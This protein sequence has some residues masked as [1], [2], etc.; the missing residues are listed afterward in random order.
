[1]NRLSLKVLIYNDPRHG[2]SNNAV[3]ATSKGSDQPAHTRR[4]IRAFASRLNNPW[5]ICYWPYTI[6]KRWLLR[7]VWVYTCQKTTL[8]EITCRGSN[9]PAYPK[10]YNLPLMTWCAPRVNSDQPVALYAFWM[11]DSFIVRVPMTDQTACTELS[12]AFI[13]HKG[14]CKQT[15]NVVEMSLSQR[16]NWWKS[17]Q[18]DL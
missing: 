17:Y 10:F 14:L 12:K 18:I 8:L 11:I 5:F 6:F 7:L 13:I 16:V 1:M 15:I 2:V 3:R 9:E 4:L